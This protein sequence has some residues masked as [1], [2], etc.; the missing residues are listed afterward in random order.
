MADGHASRPQHE[1]PPMSPQ[2][3]SAQAQE[4]PT[5]GDSSG[6]LFKIYSKSAEE[7]DIRV[8]ERWQKEAD[9]II[10]FVRPKVVLYML[11][12][13]SIAEQNGLFSAVIAAVVV[14]SVQDL[15]PDPQETSAFYLQKMYHL[16]AGPNI[17]Q[18]SVPSTLTDPSSF[19]PPTHAIWVNSLWFL[20]LVISLSCAMLATSLQQWARHYIR[21]TQESGQSPRSRARRRAFF[22]DGM[23]KFHV[24]RVVE[25][26]PILV[27][28]SLF[29][30]FVGLLIYLFN[31]NHTVFSTVM[32]WI[33]LL[34]VVYGC[35]TVLPLFWLDCPYYSPLSQP[36]LS[37]YTRISYLVLKILHGMTS[38]FRAVKARD[39]IQRCISDLRKSRSLVRGLKTAI[40]KQS[41]RI[42]LRILRRI[43]RHRREDDEL[44]KVFESI[45]GFF[46]SDKV[47]VPL[48]DAQYM[49]EDALSYFLHHTLSSNSVP[50]DVKTRRLAACLKIAGEVL[51]PDRCDYG[52]I[53]SG[54]IHAN[55]DGGLECVK[56]GHYLR[57]W[58]KTSHR[59]FNPYIR[60][61]IA[62]IVASVR[63]RHES[64]RS[65]VTL[66]RNHLG[67]EDD[68]FQE[69][70]QHGDSVLLANLIHFSRHR[71]G[72]ADRTDYFDFAVE[73][74][75]SLSRF[76]T[77]NTH[78][79]LRPHFCAVWNDLV[80]E[81]R[82]GDPYSHSSRFLR[83]IR[84]HHR[85]LH[86]GADA[87][88][89]SCLG[90]QGLESSSVYTH[91]PHKSSQ[92]LCSNAPGQRS[93]PM[94][95][96]H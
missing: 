78:P 40:S 88:T 32:C 55:W 81:S 43:F 11:H 24:P 38:L 29:V 54:M 82:N 66:A 70:L 21:I 59:R 75:R 33:A 13:N 8:F 48:D 60:G 18:P 15:K 72:D 9:G 89:A 28:L 14:V 12:I 74:V 37:C 73:V 3:S 62:V 56:I 49:I 4:E 84:R 31:I 25:I 39:H 36:A 1:A 17:S 85:R 69:Y 76:D 79:D 68:V 61:V 96:I 6:P 42:D 77:R 57:T 71:H 19:S 10:F 7:R 94:Q 51:H 34:T 87:G 92:S 91:T 5:Y 47:K 2:T 52:N 63:E 65:W 22:A 35:I 46:K 20:S 67:I 93:Y 83:A 41:P 64:N 16:Q 86:Q 44:E 26:L 90:L 58:G 30:F 95:H 80:R 27:H 45:P 53:F 50:E 23:Q